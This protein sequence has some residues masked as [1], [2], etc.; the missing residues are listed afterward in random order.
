M[1]S[2]RFCV[3]ID[4]SFICVTLGLVNLYYFAVAQ[5]KLGG[6]QD[7]ARISPI[8]F[9]SVTFGLAILC[10]VEVVVWIQPKIFE[11]IT[12]APEILWI[13]TRS[14]RCVALTL[15]EPRRVEGVV[16]IIP[17]SFRFLALGLVVLRRVEGA[18]WI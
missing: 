17:T 10:G 9:R 14:F 1:R 4:G 7:V 8:S 18:A 11:C 16:R 2:N 5:T 3:L 6:F 13:R 15:E 12:V